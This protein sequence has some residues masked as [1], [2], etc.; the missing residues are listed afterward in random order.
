MSSSK[1]PGHPDLVDLFAEFRASLKPECDELGVP[2]Y[3]PPAMARQHDAVKSFQER[4]ASIDISDW[5]IGEQVDYHVVRAEMNGVAF[6]HEVLRPWARDPGFYNITDGVY[7]RLL[8]HYSR[9]ENDWSPRVAE[10]PIAD[11]DVAGLRRK[12]NAIPAALKQASGNLTEVAGDLAVLAARVQQREIDVMGKLADTLS[13]V[14]SELAAGTERACAALRDFRDELVT[15]SGDPATPAGIGKESYNRWL[16]EVL[17]VPYTWD[18]LLTTIGNDYHRAIA[19]LK[20][21]EHKNRGLP[22]FEPTADETQNLERQGTAARQ[23]LAFL[24]DR[25]IITVPDDLE[26]LPPEH[27]PR[28]WGSSAY[29][30][31]CY[32]GF[33]EECC[34]RE[35]MT[36]IAHTFFG[37][38]YVRDRTIWYQDGDDRPIRGTIR[39]FDM[40]ESRSEALSFSIEEM[41]LQLG[42]LDERP[43]AKEITYIWMAFRAARAISDLKMHAN[44]YSMRDGIDAFVNKLPYPWAEPD[45]DAVWWDIEEA[46]RAPAHSVSY[47]GGKN[48]ILKLLAECAQQQG[49]TFD[50]RRFMDDFMGGGIIP[51]SLTRWEMTGYDDE[52]RSMLHEPSP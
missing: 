11:G 13:H 26:P 48:M 3:T 10:L 38:Y 52:L 24:R 12:M 5:N 28:T 49:D 20:L 23:L 33:F 46:L 44:E 39:L 18:E 36:Q 1:P 4:L 47:V 22:P 30:R 43:R 19:F 50:L 9:M 14:D 7:P 31:P 32:R 15:H 45:S 21:E 34:D 40:H 42:L 27:Y 17:L 35:P 25:E 41:M 8:V 16:R 29:L 6:D 2:D 51:I 37:H